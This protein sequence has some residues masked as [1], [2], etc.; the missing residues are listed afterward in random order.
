L[1]SGPDREGMV[2]AFARGVEHAE[3]QRFVAAGG[4]DR[5]VRR[6]VENFGRQRR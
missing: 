4:A 1:A 2:G 3:E 5:N 6:P